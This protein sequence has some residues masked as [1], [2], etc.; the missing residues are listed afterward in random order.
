MECKIVQIRDCFV[1]FRQLV[2]GALWR[3]YL[4]TCPFR[5]GWELPLKCFSNSLLLSPLSLNGRVNL[6]QL[7]LRQR[8]ELRPTSPQSNPQLFQGCFEI[9]FSFWHNSRSSIEHGIRQLQAALDMHT[10]RIR[11]GSLGLGNFC[12]IKSD[13]VV[14]PQVMVTQR[15]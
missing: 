9:C 15:F 10:H 13:D 2:P 12:M 11:T 7:L 1:R 4:R 5:T 14:V 8:V 3:L 6:F